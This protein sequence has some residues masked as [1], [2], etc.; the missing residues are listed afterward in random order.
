VG[1]WIDNTTPGLERAWY[2]VA[3]SREV[4]AEPMRVQLL[5]RA[6]VLVRIGAELV[7]FVDECPHRL[8]PLSA[9]KVCGTTL[10]CAYHGWEFGADGRCT[11]IPSLDAGTPI[12][13]RARLRPPYDVIERYGTVWLAPHEPVVPFLSLP[14]WED[15]SF[16]CRLDTPSRVSA[17]AFQAVDNFCDT[18]HFIAVH[19]GTFGGD[20]AAMAHPSTVE[21]EGWTVTGTYDAPF[22][23][24]DDP[25]VLA[26]ELPEIQPSTQTK[27]YWPPASM[28][29]R[30]RFPVTS[31]TFTILIAC[32]PETQGSTRIYRWFCRDDIVGD[33]GRWASCLEVEAAIMAE[34][35]AA[36][37]RY[38][39][40]GV[41][42]DPTREVNVPADKLSLGYRRVLADLLRGA[43]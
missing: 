40:H 36:L 17:S 29:L 21:R 7:A 3:L 5:G 30:M 39:H 22:R 42:V 19:A 41:P 15:P 14:E 43:T 4:G 8:F 33:E 13:A 28:L 11:T 31:S 12:T 23:V 1:E 32:Q 35:I 2:A 16:E 18:S 10:R 9:G 26:G 27:T 38:A 25:R 6:W 24:Q 20:I 37:N 34:D